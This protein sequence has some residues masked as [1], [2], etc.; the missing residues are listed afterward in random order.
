M[1]EHTDTLYQAATVEI[2]LCIEA[3]LTLLTSSP[4]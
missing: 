4:P 2:E 3:Y 1:A